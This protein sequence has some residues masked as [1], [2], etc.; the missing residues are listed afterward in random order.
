MTVRTRAQLNSDADTNLPDNTT[1]AIS[2]EDV[3][4]RIKDLADSSALTSD[5]TGA[6]NKSTPVDADKFLLLDSAASDAF[7]LPTWANIKAAIWSALGAL[8][9]AGTGKTTPV[10]A[11]MLVIADSAASDATK[12]L[13]ITNLSAFLRSAGWAV[14]GNISSTGN[15]EVDSG[16]LLIDAANASASAV[17]YFRDNTGSDQAYVYWEYSSDS[18]VL[19]RQGGTAPLVMNSSSIWTI[20]GYPV[21]YIRSY[22]VGTVPTASGRTGE[23]IYVSN[24]TGGAVVAFSDNTNWRRVTDRAIVS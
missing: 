23:L 12:K 8:I 17:L 18:L 16:A 13:T 6:A 22:T 24:E 1:R 20:S 7:K 5:I 19:N 3:R 9:S 14:T 4:Q 2:P 21:L 15:V 10:G 11:D